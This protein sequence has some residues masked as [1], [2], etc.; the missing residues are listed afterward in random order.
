MTASHVQELTARSF[1]ELVLHSSG[2]VAVDL[3]AEWCPFCREFVQV[4]G[5][6]AQE[7]ADRCEFGRV[8]V[9]LHPEILTAL[10]VK[11]VPT[12]LIYSGGNLSTKLV[13]TSSLEDLREALN[14][15]LQT[16]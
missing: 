8:N 9:E 3:Y 15:H 5:Q 10:G 11:T 14:A 7:Y 12:V 4:F 6:I 16:P 13:G 2:V 1:R